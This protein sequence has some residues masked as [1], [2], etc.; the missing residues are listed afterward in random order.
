MRQPN[1]TTNQSQEDNEANK[2]FVWP[3][4]RFAHAAPP[5]R[6]TADRKL[7]RGSV[8]NAGSWASQDF[9]RMQAKYPRQHLL[10]I[11]EVKKL[12]KWI[13]RWY[14]GCARTFFEL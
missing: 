14:R 7:G 11:V 12:A 4:G 3:Q 10:S 2:F 5:F 1:K 9:Q 13:E 6:K 8:R